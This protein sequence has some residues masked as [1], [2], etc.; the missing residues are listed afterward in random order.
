MREL[1]F[2]ELVEGR[3]AEQF[4]EGERRLREVVT[5]ARNSRLVAEAKIHYGS[6]CKACGFDFG[7]R[8]GELGADFIECHHIDPLSG[9][10][11]KN[12]PTTI[13]EVIVLCANC[14]RM[15]HR[16]KP[17]LM[18]SELKAV[19]RRARRQTSN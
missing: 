12:S 19:L 2:N 1:G 13:I 18:L 3:A 15:I 16:R 5:F 9:R 7:E 11:G 10:E 6:I 17:V 4:E 8:Y 14:H